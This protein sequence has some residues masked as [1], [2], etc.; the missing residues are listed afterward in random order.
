MKVGELRIRQGDGWNKEM[1]QQ[2]FNEEERKLVESIQVSLLGV[3][4]RLIWKD[5]K[6]GQ[7]NV[8]SGYKL[9]TQRDE[10]K[11]NK[12]ESSNKGEE[13]RLWQ[14]IWGLKV[15]KKVQQFLWRACNSLP[16]NTNLH[17]R[18]INNDT[19]CTQC[20]MESESI[21]HVMFR[22]IKAQLA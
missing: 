18:G 13:R 19:I 8:Q 15:K 17:K 3:K 10:L 22:C 12:A 7:Y 5:A 11:C 21:E 4:N 16:V 6:D 14:M 2:I 20:G 1:L 9:A